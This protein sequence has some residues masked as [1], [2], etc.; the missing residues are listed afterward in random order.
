MG[1]VAG[2][3]AVGTWCGSAAD[4]NPNDAVDRLM[5]QLA[6][7]RGLAGIPQVATPAVVTQDPR[8]AEITAWLM[9]WAE[10][11][12]AAVT[13]AAKPAAA[14][15]GD[16]RAQAAVRR[17]AAVAGPAMEVHFR[18]E[19]RTVRQ[20]RGGILA[21]PNALALQ[22]NLAPSARQELTGRGFLR[23]HADLLG[24]TN[25]DAELELRSNASDEL[26]GR[27]LRFVQRHQALPVWPTGVSLHLNA[28]GEVISLDGAYVPTP[29]L[30]DLTP[31]IPAADAV[32][33]AKAS[34]PG[35]MR[36][37]AGDPEL[38]VYAPL[39]REPRLAWRVA[40]N[41]GFTQAW[42]LV[43]DA[44]DGRVLSR[45]NRVLDA[46]VSGSGTDLEGQNRPL[47]VWQSGANYFLIDTSKQMFNPASDP[48]QKPV[49]A[50]TIADA[51]LKKINDLKG[52][53]IALITTANPNQWAI[54]DAVS[55][56]FNFSQTYD[57]FLAQHSRNSL[58]GQGGNITAVVRITEYDNAS[59][60]GNLR[61]MLFG[62]TRQY[63]AALDVVGHE[64]THGL[65]E[66][67]AGL[68][69]ENQSGALN[70]SFS[71]IFGEMVEAYVQGQND[72]KMGSKLDKI[73]RDF[74]NPG[75]LTIGGLNRPY[76]SKMS[77]FIQLQ[78]TDDQDHGG[79]HLNSSIINHTFWLLA[80][81]LPGAVGRRDAERIFFRCLTQHLQPQSQFIDARLGCLAAAEALFGKDSTQAKKV[82]EAFDAT[83]ILSAPETPAPT[84]VPVVQGDDSTLFVS[85]DPFFGE[86]TLYRREAAQGDGDDGSD[87][88]A[89]VLV[90]RPAVSGDGS[91]AL[92]VASDNDLCIAETTDGRTTQCLGRPGL[93]HSVAVSP[94]GQLGA[95]VLRDQVT[96]NPEARITLI[97]L[98]TSATQTF[99]LVAPAIDGVPVDA[100]LYAD[101][102]TFSTDSAVL[103]YDA[104]SR[105]HF[106]AGPTVERWSVYALHLATAK[107]AIVVPPIEG[108]DTG[109]P[110]MGRA[111]NRYL[112]IDALRESDGHSAII[113]LDLFTGG[114]AN[115]GL[116]EGGLGFPT[117]TGDEA[118][119]VYGQRDFNAFGSGRSL[120]RQALTGDRLG[121]QGD[122]TL[123]LFDAKLG[124]IYR[125]GAFTGTNAPP[126][127]TVT[128]PASGANVAVGTAVTMTVNAADADGTV[129][130][131]EFY[132]GDDR[133]GEDATA[134][135][136]LT[137]TPAGAGS[138]RL[139]ARAYDNLGA[140]SDSAAVLVTVGGGTPGEGPRLAVQRQ[141]N[142]AMRVTV[143][144]AA[145]LYTIQQ[146][147]D[148][149]T[150]ADIYPL[151]V[152]GSGVGFVDDAGGPANNRTLFYRARR[153]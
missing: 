142:G 115:I 133:L 89:P 144:G 136:A 139:I 123:W 47:K 106:G 93:V 76:P 122:P 145:G 74:Q 146:S 71:D 27:H 5:L 95:F 109:N 151:T 6:N 134:P 52:S 153:E 78:N 86:V 19:N 49:G 63:A 82:G 21:R 113:T 53:D 65:T 26:G 152:D 45:Q 69:Y 30:A 66:T 116:A 149:R 105:L 37:E 2:L 15:P 39:D 12:V 114:A 72:W 132:D 118:A 16:A 94:N 51:Q 137:W 70:E 43:V 91:V 23:A 1:F 108:L 67:S 31:R 87:F 8:A 79:V 84:P 36:G 112:V 92:F 107:T 88:A 4:P 128:A 98:A 38:L 32:L 148:L 18:P 101:A 119:V 73:F 57:Y 85:A 121:T 9:P 62:N 99:N 129:A 60:N 22:G 97:N 48:I 130:R 42:L 135:Y 58:D 3:W 90:S 131:V 25:P 143:R 75:A 126:T 138:H 64:L 68:V 14:N 24:L 10:A 125:R 28:A 7:R 59:W 50:I 120:V 34:V 33:R 77:E 147:N 44:L 96:G 56:A 20:I 61:I 54:P 110:S 13:P 41:V 81:G 80:E 102:M 29:A 127:L 17:L 40:L 11:H 140:A 46:G 117:F 100:L 111:G 35:G 103:Y 55:A 104:V 124:V 83:E 150:W 141:A